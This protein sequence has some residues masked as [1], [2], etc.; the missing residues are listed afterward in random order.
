MLDISF[1]KNIDWRS[2]NIKLAI[3]FVVSFVCSIVLTPG[4]FFE[5]GKQTEKKRKVSFK[6]AGIHS[7]IF[8]VLMSLLYYFYLKK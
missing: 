8:A 1:L 3:L 4:L 2:S 7:V 6:T 5:I